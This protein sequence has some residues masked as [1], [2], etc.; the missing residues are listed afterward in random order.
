MEGCTQTIRDHLL[1][2]EMGKSRMQFAETVN[3]FKYSSH[4]FID[5]I[6]RGICT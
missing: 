5:Y 4:Y 2:R 3:I 6:I 1:V